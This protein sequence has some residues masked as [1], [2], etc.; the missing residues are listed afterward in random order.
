MRWRQQSGEA[1]VF[2]D[3][4]AATAM[5][6]RMARDRW[7]FVTT[8]FV[9]AEAHALIL[10]RLGRRVATL[11][12]TELDENPSTEIVRVSEDDEQ[13]A[14]AII[15]Q[16]ADKDFS[17][18]DALSF[19]VMERRRIPAAFTFDNDFA[20]FGLRVLQPDGG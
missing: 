2:V 18:T 19:A 3:T 1:R 12:L 14:R 15:R 7:T 13:R 10:R 11:F 9:A 5:L 4:S 8:N 6:S 16:Y 20:Q 17:L